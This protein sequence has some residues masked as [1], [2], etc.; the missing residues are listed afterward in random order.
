MLVSLPAVLPTQIISPREVLL[1]DS[2]QAGRQGEKLEKSTLLRSFDSIAVR[3]NDKGAFIGSHFRQPQD[4]SEYD[5]FSMQLSASQ[6]TRLSFRVIQDQGVISADVTLLPGENVKVF[7]DGSPVT[8]PMPPPV[9]SGYYR[10]VGFPAQLD[11]KR[12]KGWDLVLRTPS[13]STVTLHNLYGVKKST[14]AFPFVDRYGQVAFRE[15]AGKIRNDSDLRVPDAPFNDGLKIPNDRPTAE[16]LAFGWKVEKNP[17]G[18]SFFKAPDGKRMWSLGVTTVG[19]TKPGRVNTFGREVLS[20]SA[21][22]K[23]DQVDHYE[24]N[25]NLKF[26][27]SWIKDW[28]RQTRQRLFDWGFNTLSVYTSPFQLQDNPSPYVIEV[29]TTDF[30]RRLNVPYGHGKSLPDPYADG[31]KNWIAQKHGSELRSH[32]KKTQFI[33]FYVDGELPWGD[34][35]GEARAKFQVPLAIFASSST[36]PAK[37]ALIEWLRT[38]YTSISAFN[39]AYNS[40]LTSWSSLE[41]PFMVSNPDSSRV[42]ADLSG[43]LTEFASQYAEGVAKARSTIGIKSLILGSRDLA[44]VPEEVMKGTSRWFDVL[45]VTQ[46]SRSSQMY[47]EKY[48]RQSKPLLLAE[49]A[50]M[51]QEGNAMSGV[52][53]VSTIVAPDQRTRAAWTEEVLRS[54]ARQKNVIGVHWFCYVDQPVTGQLGSRE[55]FAFGLVNVADQPYMPLVTTFRKF[56]AQMYNQRS[57]R[58]STY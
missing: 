44:N 13:D 43:F 55:N 17:A 24:A 15:W 18:F 52:S 31:F 14:V 3:L 5:G 23:T 34:E 46:Y 41:Q 1:W 37:K 32:A 8:V 11:W 10:H 45:S 27:P 53:F 33:G 54:A 57:E 20:S 48:Q 16:G 9:Y 12:I 58:V 21:A 26:G 49:F 42:Q 22:L 38:R 19:P 30:P 25:L 40:N 47:W 51:A 50:F 7:F 35:S 39:Q 56:A 4:W 2:R 36:Q 29:M 6:E 28:S